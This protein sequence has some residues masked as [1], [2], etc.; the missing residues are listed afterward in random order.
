[1]SSPE[2]VLSQLDLYCS[3]CDQVKS[4]PHL[5]LEHVFSELSMNTVTSSSFATLFVCLLSNHNYRYFFDN[6]QLRNYI[7]QIFVYARRH[8]RRRSHP[9]FS[10]VDA[11][12]LA[13]VTL[14]CQHSEVFEAY[15]VSRL[16][17]IIGSASS[18]FVNEWKLLCIHE[19]YMTNAPPREAFQAH[20]N[21][22]TTSTP[23][24]ALHSINPLLRDALGDVYIGLSAKIKDLVENVIKAIPKFGL[25]LAQAI[26]ESSKKVSSLTGA[27]KAAIHNWFTDVER[28][29]YEIDCKINKR[30]W[31]YDDF[32]EEWIEVKP[33]YDERELRLTREQSVNESGDDEIE[34]ASGELSEEESD[35]MNDSAI[36]LVSPPS[37]YRGFYSHWPSSSPQSRTQLS[38]TPTLPLQESSF[39]YAYSHPP[40]SVKLTPRSNK[41]VQERYFKLLSTPATARSSRKNSK[42]SWFARV[43]LA[44]RSMSESDNE[45]DVTDDEVSIDTDSRRLAEDNLSSNVR[46]ESNES[47]S[48]NDISFE[49]ASPLQDRRGTI[50]NLSSQRRKSQR[51]TETRRSS[52]ENEKPLMRSI[53]HQYWTEDRQQLDSDGLELDELA[54]P[55]VQSRRP[56]SDLINNRAS[57]YQEKKRKRHNERDGETRK[58]VVVAKG[59]DSDEDE[60][61]SF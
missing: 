40:S 28:R 16:I 52:L 25:S 21:N 19:I 22:G 49:Y 38:S 60:I 30:N 6:A 33:V 59:V 15:F 36:D 45:H 46:E 31:V 14:I 44:S 17:D 2:T 7:V 27:E 54:L 42:R 11:T 39:K 48:Y 34:E 26:A 61:C 53:L 3:L 13:L 8:V 4:S 1:M 43:R 47:I 35:Q 18:R 41:R 5:L 12:L 10:K 50:L 56:L 29:A 55:L 58:R 32:I 20:F 24:A 37:A 9:Q 51:S 23:T 57:S